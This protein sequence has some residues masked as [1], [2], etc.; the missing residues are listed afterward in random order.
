MVNKEW[1]KIQMTVVQLQMDIEARRVS[2][3]ENRADRLSQGFR[4]NHKWKNNVPV[5][6]PCNLDTLLFQVL[7]D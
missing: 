6:V 7:Y 5:D 2:S 4:D 3:K 1:K